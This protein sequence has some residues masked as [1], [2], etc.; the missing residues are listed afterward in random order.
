MKRYYI[1]EA[2]CGMTDGGMACGPA[3]GSIVV[4]VKFKEGHK[5]QYLSMVE[6]QGFPNFYLTNLDVFDDLVKEDFEDEEFQKIM[7]ASYI[8]DF[9]GVEIGGEYADVF[10]GIHNSL[11]NP[12]VP[13]LRYIIALIRCP[14]ED[15][16]DLIQKAAGRYVDEI[17]VPLSDIEEEYMEDWE[18]DEEEDSEEFEEDEFDIEL[19]ED[20]DRE[21]LY[22]IRLSLETD[23]ETDSVF[24]DLDVQVLKEQ[25][26]R[27]D[28]VLARCEDEDDYEEWKQT[29]IESEYESLK[30]R[31][32][33]TYS[34]LFAGIG[35]Y[36]QTIPEEQ[37]E[38][39]LCWIQGNGSAFCDSGR[40]ASEEE[41]KH[42]IAMTAGAGIM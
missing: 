34:Y 6:V 23:I 41:I 35:Q 31:K 11:N 18:D 40:V 13:L 5:T 25:E 1:E 29:Y 17:E 27:L 28:A 22:R 8:T 21:S 9:D 26:A 37:K 36:K 24:H 15:T 7:D 32:F 2:K 3:D 14:I 10:D 30:D 38:S 19:P 20:L 39:F 12:A 4:T 42:Y 16:E 33:L